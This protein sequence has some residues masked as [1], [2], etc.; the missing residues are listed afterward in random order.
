MPVSTMPCLVWR[1]LWYECIGLANSVAFR[2][3]QARRTRVSFLSHYYGSEYS[4]SLF[5]RLACHG[6]DLG[7]RN[8][9]QLWWQDLPQR[10]LEVL[11]HLMFFIRVFL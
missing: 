7:G 2:G 8:S 9:V 1:P 4:K 11:M 6:N 3:G 10:R 5:A